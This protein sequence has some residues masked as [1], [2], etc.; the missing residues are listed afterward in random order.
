LQT[1]EKIEISDDPPHP[2]LY[3]EDSH[4]LFDKMDSEQRGTK[5]NKLFEKTALKIM[6]SLLLIS[7]F[8][9]V[10][11]TSLIKAHPK[12]IYVDDD[13]IT[14][15]WDGTPEHPYKNIISGLA[16]AS[17][18]DTI[19][20]YNGTYYEHLVVNKRVSL[21][22]QN[23]HGTIIDG[24]K[25]GN[26]VEV[27]VNNAIVMNFTIQHSG[28]IYHNSGVYLEE[29]TS[30]TISHSIITNN[31]KGIYLIDSSNNIL[32]DNDISQNREAIYMTNSNNNTS[33]NNKFSNNEFAM[34]LTGA[35]NNK[36]F[37][38]NFIDNTKS[39]SSIYSTN[40][41]DNG[42]EGNY[43]SDYTGKDKDQD[44]IG[45]SPYIIT[46]NNQ[47][48]HPLM[49]TYSDFTVIY[50]NETHHIST[51]CNS[52]ISQFQFN[53]TLKMLSLNVTGINNTAGFCRITIPHL[54]VNKPHIVVV[55]DEQVNATSLTISNATHTFLYFTYNHSTREVKILS[56]PFYELLEKYG[57]LLENYSNLNSTYYQLLAD[58]DLLNQTLRKTLTNYIQL[59]A[60]Y[61]ALNKTYW[62][63]LANYT[64]LQAS[65]S[66][67]NETYEH[68]RANYTQLL[69]DYDTLLEQYNSLTSI[70]NKIESEYANTRTI[71]WY[72]SVAATAITVITSSL[73]IRYHR[74]FKEE[75]KL[76]EKYKSELER[77]RLLDI[78]RTQF[79]ADV[80]R[81]QDKI[82][83]FEQK[84]G[85]PV[86][87]RET[88]QD[89][90]RSLELKKKKEE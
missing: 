31:Y 16:H 59:L 82:E 55:N 24:S 46:A 68:I 25:T 43:W 18:G 36:A 51:I 2:Y 23:K 69:A 8:T 52:T 66:S 33:T 53:E 1:S 80:Q 47:D 45:E 61:N 83:K 13:N 27:V 74:R 12:T 35:S 40:F 41:W 79:E 65:H 76:V 57:T 44:G 87:P 89:V 37:H 56:Q 17:D 77:I 3:L 48:N 29:I 62:Q 5:V 39:I 22:G 6:F 49:G 78:A 73:T 60:Y 75:K 20:V 28:L 84:Y 71:L 9:L 21:I 85:I 32:T 26:V 86:R 19:F 50:E 58:Y 11:N 67:L 10:F 15:P 63:M 64:Q 38:N 42:I 4:K 70:Y 14:G 88:L 30:S 34:V 81:R 54:L 72:V 7:I 90:I